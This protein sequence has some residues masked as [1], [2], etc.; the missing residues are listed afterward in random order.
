M[1]GKNHEWVPWR[2]YNPV[3]LQF[4]I[5]ISDKPIPENQ[6]DN[7]MGDQQLNQDEKIYME[8]Y[9]KCKNFTER[10]STYQ[11]GHRNNFIHLLACN[12]NRANIP[13]DIT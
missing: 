1:P 6:D 12:C 10:I 2:A 7:S 3:A 9:S 11:E 13:E 8:R 5:S 4:N